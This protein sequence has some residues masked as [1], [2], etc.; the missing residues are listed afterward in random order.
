M[1]LPNHKTKIVAT[2]GPASN[3]PEILERLIRAG[4][5]I[6]R[7][8]FSHGSFDQHAEVIARIRAACKATGRRVAIMSDLPGPK[9]RLGTID[10]EPVC[11]ESGNAFTL[12]GEDIIGS[13]QRAS[14]SFEPLPRV[15]K[16][17]D[18]LFLN[19]GLVQLLVVQVEG[20][21]VHCTVAVGGELR[22]RKGLN[23][24]RIDLGI[25]AFTDHDHKCLEFAL[26][27]GIDAISH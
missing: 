25:S 6:A 1:I 11:L 8:N 20:R 21:E 4:M 26:A 12:T 18:S 16:P 10:P 3:S 7:L 23:L 19:D 13:A 24:P 15:V 27:C 2:I 5:N 17:G 22:S 14:M 9:M